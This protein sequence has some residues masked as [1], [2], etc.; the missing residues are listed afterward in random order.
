MFRFASTKQLRGKLSKLKTEVLGSG[1]LE[2]SPEPETAS[3]DS[4][5]DM[6]GAYDPDEEDGVMKDV[7]CRDL[8]AWRVSIPRLEPRNDAVTG[9]ACFVFII[10]VKVVILYFTSLCIIKFPGSKD[11]CHFREGWTGSRM[12]C[13]EAVPGVLQSADCSRPVPRSL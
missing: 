13:G 2:G 5:Y 7:E 3:M 1:P 8:S 11:R 9:K 10:Q 12:D 6:T 4:A